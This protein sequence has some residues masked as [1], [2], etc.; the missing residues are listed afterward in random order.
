MMI[1]INPAEMLKRARDSQR[2][3]D[4]NTLKTAIAMYLTEVSSASLTNGSYAYSHTVATY[5]SS[6]TCGG[7]PLTHSSTSQAVD[8]SGWIPVNFSNITGGSPISSEPID[9]NPTNGRYYV[10]ISTTSDNTFELIANM[11]SIA[12]SSGGSSDVESKDGGNPNLTG[13]YE[14]GTAMLISTTTGCYQP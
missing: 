3:S 6:G 4:L 5:P 2:I 14:V 8:G 12:Y 11:E 7:Y 10:Y 13:Y 1:V 9:P